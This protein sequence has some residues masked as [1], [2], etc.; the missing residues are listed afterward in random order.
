MK[1]IL[2]RK[3][4]MTQVFTE[5]GELIPV[6]VIEALP[7]TV[8]Q[9]KT[10]E[11]DGYS[12]IQLGVFDKRKIAYK[13]PEQGHAKKANVVPKRYIREFRGFEGDYKLGDQVKLSIFKSGD[14]VDIQGITKGHGY[15]GPIK[16]LGQ[17]TGPSSHGSRYHRRSGSMGAI[18]NRVFKGKML[19]GQMGGNLRTVQKLLIAGIDLKKNLLL[20]KGNVPGAN[21]SF[22]TIKSTVKPFKHQDIKLVGQSKKKKASSSNENKN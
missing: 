9:V 3:I 22:I 18:I 15:Q 16:K 4:G 17:S 7:N 12:S 20:I 19:P 8:L 6:T 21:N 5:N 2:G 14:Y 11:N 13:K 1:G 10:Q